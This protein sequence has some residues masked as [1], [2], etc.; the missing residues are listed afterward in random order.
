MKCNKNRLRKEW[1]S[2]IYA[3]E[4]SKNPLLFFESYYEAL[5]ERKKQ[6]VKYNL[7]FIINL[8]LLNQ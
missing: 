1:S 8:I 7:P 5:L 4:Y 3:S 6:Q 2:K